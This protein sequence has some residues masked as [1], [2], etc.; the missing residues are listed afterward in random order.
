MKLALKFSLFLLVSF[1]VFS[2]SKSVKG[3]PKEDAV[4]MVNELITAAKD[5]DYNKINKIAGEYYDYYS[6]ADLVD[7]VS[8]LKSIDFDKLSED[9]MIMWHELVQNDEFQNC[10]NVMR[11]DLLEGETKKEAREKGIW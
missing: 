4:N 2:C 5:K 7:R 3:N 6:K 9:D 8:F 10:P 1:I 11:L